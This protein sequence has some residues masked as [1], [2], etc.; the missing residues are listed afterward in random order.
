MTMKKNPRFLRL[1]ALLLMLL[2]TVLTLIYIINTK[3]TFFWRT[4]RFGDKQHSYTLKLPWTWKI[5]AETSIP[6]TPVIFSHW[7]NGILYS[8]MSYYVSED[9]QSLISDEKR[10]ITINGQEAIFSI[11]RF[12]TRAGPVGQ[13]QNFEGYKYQYTIPDGQGAY[14]IDVPV[15]DS[16]YGLKANSKDQKIA[17]KIVQTFTITKQ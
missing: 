7:D 14:I 13:E 11:N 2:T 3:T 10:T 15:S 5:Q 8:F 17:E 9:Y 16:S 6:M 1:A 4:Y 12:T